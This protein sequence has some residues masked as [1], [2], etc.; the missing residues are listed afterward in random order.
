MK[1]IHKIGM[2]LYTV[3]ENFKT[4]EQARETFRTLKRLGYDEAQTAGCYG[5]DYG[6]FYRMAADAGIEIVGTHDDWALMRDDTEKAIELHKAL[7]TTNMGI[8][9]YH[10]K[11]VA[12]VEAFLKEA[13]RIAARAAEEGMKFTYHNHSHE[14]IRL[15]NGRTVMDMLVEG[16]DPVNTSFVLDTHWV[17]N[18]GGDVCAWIEKLAGRI[19]ILHLKDMSVV[20]DENG[21]ARNHIAAIGAGNM[22]FH[23]IIAAAVKAGVKYYC[24][25]QDNCPVDFEETVKFSS[26]YL[27]RNFMQD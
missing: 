20:F 9:G 18:A 3:R 24:V 21:R 19:D 15:E 14:F 22:D 7:H 6:E 13:N 11:T 1:M 8:G 25:E 10:A 16:L 27:H 17:Q 5:Y 4:P 12:E 2:Q 23:R 26:D